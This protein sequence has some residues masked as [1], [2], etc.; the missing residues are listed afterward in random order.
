MSNHLCVHLVSPEKLSLHVYSQSTKKK[1]NLI[2]V[3]I[4]H[5]KKL[6]LSL[7]YTWYVSTKTN[8]NA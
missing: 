2:I 1:K 4:T 8:N 3:D 5:L 7:K 6:R